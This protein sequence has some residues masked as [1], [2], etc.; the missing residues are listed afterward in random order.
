[1]DRLEAFLV[2]RY[3][4]STLHSFGSFAAGIYLPNSDMDVVLLSEEYSNRGRK[5][6]GSTTSW[7]YS[8]GHALESWRL[9]VPGT[10]EVIAKARVPLVKFVDRVTGI[11]VD[12][13]FENSTGLIANK[14]FQIWKEK[15]P[16]MPVMVTIIKQFLAMRG[17]N[18]VVNGGLGGF[19]VTC[20]VVSLLQNM[21]QVQSGNMI[22]DHHLGEILLE[23]LDLYGNRFEKT[24]VGIRFSP[25]GYFEKV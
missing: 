19:S 6:L 21:P 17:L 10:V 14:T 13:S 12:L 1:M 2:A 16:V 5:V 20:L 4:R 15:Y 11:K 18:E 7:Y 23:F 25:P 9:C 24:L 8:L 3:P 22:P